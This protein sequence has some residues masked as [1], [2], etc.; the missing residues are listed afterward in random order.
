MSPK[1]IIS[2]ALAMTLIMLTVVMTGT[3]SITKTQ[4]SVNQNEEKHSFEKIEYI[5]AEI[6]GAHF[7][8]KRNDLSPSYVLSASNFTTSAV[9][10][11]TAVSSAPKSAKSDTASQKE[12]TAS[13]A[14]YP[15]TAAQR[16]KIERVLMSS[17]GAY[18]SLMAKANAQVILDR[19]KSGRFG[20]TIDEVLDA[21]HQFEKPYTGRVNSKV[22]EAVRMVFDRG[23]RVTDAQIYYYINPYISE[24][25]PAVWSKDKRYVV[26]IGEGKFIHEYWTDKDE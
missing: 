15:L 12:S 19:V 18:G 16:D 20:K 26:T 4:I 11:G 21:P 13:K 7:L 9:N 14:Y 8:I 1:K 24:I 3:N 10:S 25:S 5:P 17:C 23:E 6:F 2:A 22:K